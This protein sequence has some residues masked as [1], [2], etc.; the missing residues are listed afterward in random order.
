VAPGVAEVSDGFACGPKCGVNALRLWKRSGARV[1]EF[2]YTKLLK[3]RIAALP[4]IDDI[5]YKDENSLA[6]SVLVFLII[7]FV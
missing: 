5:K 2:C 7:S 4:Y 6:K 3:G 1:R